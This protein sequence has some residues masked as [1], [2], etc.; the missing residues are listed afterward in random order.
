MGQFENKKALITGGA[1]GIGK[2]MGGLLLQ[3]GLQTLVIWDI[4]KPCFKLQ[5]MN[6]KRRV[7]T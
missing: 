1:S 6:G 5:R 3:K 2:L 7:T 4:T